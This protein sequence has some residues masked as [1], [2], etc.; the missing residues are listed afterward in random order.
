LK[1]TGENQENI[2]I[3]YGF[4]SIWVMFRFVNRCYINAASPVGLM[5]NER[6][7]VRATSA[8]E[9]LIPGIEVTSEYYRIGP[10]SGGAFLLT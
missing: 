3:Y 4:S 1:L 2:T 10:A 9:P 7:P 8:R 5:F 6:W